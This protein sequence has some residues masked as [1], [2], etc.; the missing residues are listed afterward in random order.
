MFSAC[1]KQLA[2]PEQLIDDEHVVVILGMYHHLGLAE[3]GNV[4]V[5]PVLD[6][7]V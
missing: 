4:G 6:G 1:R 5:G 3:G 2:S 7:R